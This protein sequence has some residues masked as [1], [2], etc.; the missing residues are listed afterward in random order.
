MAVLKTLYFNG[1]EA[2]EVQVQVHISNGYPSLTI[3]G[4]VDKAISESKERIFAAIQSMGFALPAKKIV[5][6]LAP[7]NL[8]KDGS[9]FDL[10][11]ALAILIES[12]LIKINLDNFYIMGEISLN[13]KIEAVNGVLAA[14]VYCKQVKAGLICPYE[15]SA[16]VSLVKTPEEILTP[17]N[18]KHLIDHFHG[19]ADCKLQKVAIDKVMPSEPAVRMEEVI[20]QNLAKR[21]L[22]IASA[23]GHNILMSGHPGTGKSMLANAMLGILP[24]MSHEEVI[25]VNALHSLAG[26]IG[27]EDLVVSRPFRAPHHSASMP[28]LVGGGKHCRPGEITLAHRGVLFLDELPE[29][30]KSVLDALRQPM[31]TN[32]VVVARSERVVNY[33]ANFQLV[34]AM[35]P[36]KC[37]YYKDADKQCRKV[38]FCAQDYMGRIPGPIID[39]IDLV[40]E[41]ENDNLQY[42]FGRK[43]EENAYCTTEQA[44]QIVMN[45]RARQAK[46]YKHKNFNSNSDLKGDD[47]QLYCAI[48]EGSQ[49]LIKK[50]ADQKGLSMR[51][52]A[53]LL[54][55][56]RTI[57]DIEGSD[58]IEKNHILEAL[59]YRL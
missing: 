5:V 41:V 52:Y 14:A 40:I 44:L 1:L 21:G 4:M 38:P 2:S 3:V 25:E 9:Y 33:M 34:A 15:N 53:R 49:E 24:P 48:E 39:R 59:Q 45:A 51:G 7:S 30:P 26:L 32:E 35:N 20:G 36:C 23:G 42:L 19:N 50:Y 58:N 54:R 18:L 37:G 56:A 46:R 43:T 31:E 27:K 6:N 10:P 55:V 28:A 11:I 16:E 13:G 57:A 17:K 8:K 12:K 22:I 29:F 47:L